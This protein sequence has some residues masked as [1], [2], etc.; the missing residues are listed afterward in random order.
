MYMGCQLVVLLFTSSIIKKVFFLNI[1]TVIRCNKYCT[2]IK[3][4]KFDQF[5]MQGSIF[6]TFKTYQDFNGDKPKII[7]NKSTDIHNIANITAIK[8]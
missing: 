2:V 6:L 5:L 7:I 4:D 1:S 8:N 3:Y